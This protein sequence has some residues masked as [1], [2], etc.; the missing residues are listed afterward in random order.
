MGKGG[1]PSTAGKMRASHILVEKFT[2]AQKVKDE[3]NSGSDFKALA[4][5]Y[6]SCPSKKKGGDLGWFVRGQMVSEFES[7]VIRMT[8]GETSEPIKTKFGYHIIKR[9]G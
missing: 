3:L 2:Q 6:S 9:T 5:K 4:E 7:A 1:S 8:V